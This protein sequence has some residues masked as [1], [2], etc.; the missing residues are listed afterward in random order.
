MLHHP[1]LSPSCIIFSVVLSLYYYTHSCL[2]LDSALFLLHCTSLS[3][4]CCTVCV[5][6]LA[7]VSHSTQTYEVAAARLVDR[8]IN[9][10]NGLLL[11]AGTPGSGRS[12]TL[13][14]HA[15]SAAGLLPLSLAALARGWRGDTCSPLQASHCFP[16][17]TFVVRICAAEVAPGGEPPRDL[18]QAVGGGSDRQG[19]CAS[20]RWTFSARNIFAA[21]PSPPRPARGGGAGGGE[22]ERGGCGGGGGG[23]WWS[24]PD[25]VAALKTSRAL[26][27]VSE[28]TA[29]GVSEALE[30]I[31]HVSALLVVKPNINI[32]M[33]QHGIFVLVSCVFCTICVVLYNP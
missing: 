32:D 2:S 20:T 24:D 23:G 11:L 1:S 10:G 8:A 26:V 33:L 16:L 31:R 21:I 27:G 15:P 12:Y 18:V 25:G 4:S 6:F 7:P 5:F 3:V 9:G 13:W 17:H 28:V 19:G 14:G 22:A 30:L 29:G